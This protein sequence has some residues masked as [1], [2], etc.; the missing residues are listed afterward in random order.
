MTKT[1]YDLLKNALNKEYIII[2]EVEN[3]IE[4]RAAGE[5]LNYN[6]GNVVLF[7]KK[8]N[9]LYHIPF[10]GIKWMLPSLKSEK[11]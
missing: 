9:D 7:D 10:S 1:E 11:L 8:K 5:L 3:G 2:Y 6:S 4:K